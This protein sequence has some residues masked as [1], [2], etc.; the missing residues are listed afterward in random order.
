MQIDAVTWLQK[1]FVKR[2]AK[3]PQYSERAFARTLGLSPA[4]LNYVLNRKKKL[5]PKRA[6]AIA[7]R[8]NWS[9]LNTFAFVQAV[10]SQKKKIA[11]G[12]SVSAEN[13]HEM[14]DWYYFAIVEATEFASIQT[15][16][17][18]CSL[19][20]IS[21]NEA[22]F[23]LETLLRNGLLA[24]KNGKYRRSHSEYDTPPM[25]SSSIRKFHRQSLEKASLSVDEQSPEARELRS[26]TL[27]FDS[28]RL[29]EIRED[30][31]RMMKKIEKKYSSGKKDSVYQLNL[32]FH[33][34]DKEL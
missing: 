26:L 31:R 27:A 16:T 19:F 13:F 11:V 4:F 8:L 15:A 29:E 17:D 25:S 9:E 34:L 20:E 6:L 3:N 28:G 7:Q 33:R 18:I 21:A 12:H 23:A 1:E 5:G 10:S 14:A 30:I 2:R 22:N 24:K 32:A